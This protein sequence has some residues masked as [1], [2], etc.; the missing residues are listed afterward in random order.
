MINT[1]YTALSGMNAF[2]K[3]LDAIS[4][5]VAN[6]NTPGFKA[7]VPLFLDVVHRSAAGALLDASGSSSQGAGVD[8][9]TENASFNEGEL[10]S[11]GN[12]LDAAVDGAGFFV[13]QNDGQ[14]YYTR[15]GQFEFDK[16]G[17]LV[18]RTSG[19]RVMMS[20]SSQA[21]SAF[22]VDAFRSYA[23]KATANVTLT[24]NLGRTGSVTYELPSI[25]V[26]DTAGGSHVLTA[27]FV[28]DGTD[29]LKWTVEIHDDKDAVLGTA[30]LEFNSDGTPK[31]LAAPLVAHLTPTDLPAFDITFNL[32]AAGTYAG[33]TSLVNDNQSHLQLLRQDGVAFGSLTTVDFDDKGQL[34]LHYSNGEKLTPATL[35]LARFTSTNELVSV[36]SGQYVAPDAS[37]PQLGT[38][39]SHGL[40]R[41][42]GGQVELSNVQL[43]DQ[44]TDLIII[45]RGYQGSSQMASVANEMIQQLLAM[46]QGR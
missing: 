4:N 11:T 39:Q 20:T 9:N 6:L 1:I 8:V 27:K 33:V 12:P 22:N 40:G 26:Y 41:L 25:T 30:T 16:D 42:V 24:G 3:G 5:N 35:L 23:P 31:A 45:Q 2:S 36:G 21:L 44:F 43:T 19:A 32:G 34:T 13:L 29:P 46:G 28:Q 37:E 17:Y 18:D 14:T 15:A 10:R 7:T 38:A